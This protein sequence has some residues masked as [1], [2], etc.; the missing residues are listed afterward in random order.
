MLSQPP[1]ES[2]ED[3]RVEVARRYLAESKAATTDPNASPATWWGRL[4]NV[5][6][7]LLAVIDEQT[8]ASK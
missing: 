2:P 3:H 6:E 7:H 5:V 4:E 8:E 1:G